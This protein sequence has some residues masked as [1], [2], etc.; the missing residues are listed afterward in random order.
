M[1]SGVYR[2]RLLQSYQYTH[3]SFACLQHGQRG[4]YFKIAVL[5]TK[6]CLS[7]EGFIQCCTGIRSSNGTILVGKVFD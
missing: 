1:T 4:E 3:I 2:M 7:I 5:A 6:K